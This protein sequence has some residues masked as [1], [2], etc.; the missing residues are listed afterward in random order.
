METLHNSANSFLVLGLMA[1]TTNRYLLDMDTLEL[2]IVKTATDMCYITV[3][4][5]EPEVLLVEPVELAETVA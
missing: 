3:E 5:E 4:L 1:D 2:I